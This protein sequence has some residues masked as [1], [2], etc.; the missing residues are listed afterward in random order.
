MWQ[1]VKYKN[2]NQ[3]ER[4]PYRLTSIILVCMPYPTQ[5][6]N[7]NSDNFISIILTMNQTKQYNPS[8]ILCVLASPNSSTNLT[9][10]QQSHY[11]NPVTDS[12]QT[13]ARIFKHMSTQN[14]PKFHKSTAIAHHPP[15]LCY[16]RW[17]NKRS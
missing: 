13:Q 7:Q 15:R 8:I 4:M 10:A 6:R 9:D 16:E 12:D 5:T 1:L 14:L 3:H 11:N 17:S 2:E